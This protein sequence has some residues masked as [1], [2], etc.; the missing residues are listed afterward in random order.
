M[1]GYQGTFTIEWRCLKPEVYGEEHGFTSWSGNGHNDVKAEF[2]RLNPDY[3]V[4]GVTLKEN[5]EAKEISNE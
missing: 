3:E 5:S 4:I 2:V 1:A